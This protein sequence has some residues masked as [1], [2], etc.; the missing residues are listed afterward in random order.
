MAGIEDTLAD[1]SEE[2]ADVSESSP[3]VDSADLVVGYACA[4]K[5][6]ED[7]NWYRAEVLAIKGKSILF[8]FLML[9]Y[10]TVVVV[11][12]IVWVKSFLMQKIS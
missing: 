8:K 9:L 2:L 10:S 1:L 11:K 4:S 7:N 6:S 5:Y 12:L 3:G